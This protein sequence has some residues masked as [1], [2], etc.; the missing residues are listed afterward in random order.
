MNVAFVSTIF[1]Y[2][3]G[4]ADKLWTL[5]AE[6]AQIENHNI[7]LAAAR[8]TEV[9]PRIQAMR[10]CGAWLFERE[11]TTA[12]RGKRARLRARWRRWLHSRQSLVATLDRFEPDVLILCQGGTFDFLLEDEL[13]E[14]LA[15]AACPLIVVCQSNGEEA[16]LTGLNYEAARQW[17]LQAAVFVFVSTHNLA[18]AERQV[19]IRPARSHVVQ[20]PVESV[21]CRFVWPDTPELRLASVARLDCNTKGFDVA[22]PAL[23]QALGTERGW[24]LD[25]F[26][27]G[28]D[29]NRIRDLIEAHALQDRIRLHG[30]QADVSMIW[31]SHH[32]LFLPS[33][34]E[35]VSLAMLEAMAGGRPVLVTDVGGTS[36]WV[37]EGLTGF[38]SP[39][40][41]VPDLVKAL[42]RA[43]KDRERWSAIGQAAQ[44]R[45]LEQRDPAPGQTLLE[46][47]T[48]VGTNR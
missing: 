3:W 28:P 8:Q 41:S 31:K 23:A 30:F 10:S 13:L 2:P 48:A 19:G 25:I 17:F 16:P 15:A 40:C 5:A 1:G 26:G 37:C 6:A 7:L 39:T 22:I 45:F 34:R 42:A 27:Q 24:C 38:I 44:R 46:L 14:W 20:N 11:A 47:I 18:L 36:D 33:R 21:P 4:G 12:L 32:L 29:E 35:G 9:H 43:W